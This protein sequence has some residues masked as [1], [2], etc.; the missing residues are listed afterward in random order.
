MNRRSRLSLK[1]KVASYQV[2]GAKEK[3]LS[4]KSIIRTLQGYGYPAYNNGD[5][6]HLIFRM[7][8]VKQDL[9]AACEK[10][11]SQCA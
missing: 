10:T 6:N 5:K 7:A 4:T 1:D 8:V 3:I 9:L 11:F 2:I